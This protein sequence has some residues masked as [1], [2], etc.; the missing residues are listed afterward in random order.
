MSEAFT[1]ERYIA[2]AEEAMAEAELLIS[3]G[4][5]T[6]A[7]SRAYYAMFDAAWASLLRTAPPE[8]SDR[9]STHKALIRAF[10]PFIVKPGKVP[11]ELG[12]I[13]NQAEEERLLADYGRE[14][15][16][17]EEGQAIVANARLFLAAI[18]GAFEL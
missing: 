12:R 15:L 14:M 9:I 5:A 13:L 17:V 1:P 11:K 16:T 10:G 2:K 4:F 3:K 8:A 6:G 18:R 7:V